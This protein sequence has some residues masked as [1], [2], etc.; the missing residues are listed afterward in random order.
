MGTMLTIPTTCSRASTSPPKAL[1][2]DVPSIFLLFVYTVYIPICRI[3]NNE[4]V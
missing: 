1:R 2:A 3:K 4:L